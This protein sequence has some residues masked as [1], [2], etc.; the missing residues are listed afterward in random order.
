MRQIT[1][2]KVT[3]LTDEDQIIFVKGSIWGMI[4]NNNTKQAKN[5]YYAI[6]SKM[7]TL[8]QSNDLNLLISWLSK[9]GYEVL[10]ADPFKPC[11]YSKITQQTYMVNID[12]VGD[13]D[14]K[15]IFVAYDDDGVDVNKIKLLGII[16]YIGDGHYN[17][18]EFHDDAN[19]SGISSIDYVAEY[20]KLALIEQLH[21]KGYLLLVECEPIVSF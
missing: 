20:S 1:F 7:I 6:T 9:N 13:L 16:N 4:S 10:K 21:K 8:F 14:R 15:N 5:D 18:L 19:F 11:V 2:D 3:P 12:C 17:I